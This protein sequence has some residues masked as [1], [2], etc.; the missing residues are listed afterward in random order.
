[1]MTCGHLLTHMIRKFLILII[2]YSF[3]YAA[4]IPKP[5]HA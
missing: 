2:P 4:I 1:M 5:N 3:V